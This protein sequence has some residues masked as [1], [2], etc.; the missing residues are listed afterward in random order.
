MSAIYQRARPVRWEDIVGQEHI[1]DV[2]RTALEQGK[3]GHAYLF[4]GPRGVGK[5][6]TARLIAMTANC[7]T[8]TIKPCGECENCLTVRA[9][10]HPDVTEID[11]ASNNSVNDIRDLREKVTLAAM[12]GGKKIYI[13]DEAHMMSKSAFNAFLKTLEEPPEHV[14]FI[15]AT[16]E[17][18]KIIPTIL[19]RCQHYRFRR[20]TAEEI[21]SKLTLLVDAEGLEADADALKL[22]GRLADGAM[23]DGE[24]LLE[25]MLTTGEHITRLAVERALGLPP[26]ERVSHIAQALVSD[27]PAQTFETARQLYQ[28]G[29]AA[30]TIVSGLVN[31]LSAALHTEL[32]I[33]GEEQLKLQ[34]AKIPRLLRL[35]AALDQQ[36]ERFVRSADGQSLELAL[37]H[38]L[39]AA[40]TTDATGTQIQTAPT[41]TVQAQTNQPRRDVG[42][43]KELLQRL[44][45]LE[46]AFAQLAQSTQSTRPQSAPKTPH[47]TPPHS[48]QVHPSQEL[49]TAK[50]T[51]TSH[52]SHNTSQSGQT[53]PP[54]TQIHSAQA[55]QVTTNNN[56]WAELLERAD[57]ELRAFLRPVKVDHQG[58]HLYL[59]Y[60]DKAKFHAEH[61]VQSKLEQLLTLVL[62]TFGPVTLEVTGP[63]SYKRV[64]GRPQPPVQSAKSTPS[65]TQTHP[66]A[67][68]THPQ[69]I[70]EKINEKAAS[71][72]LPAQ[73]RAAP[74]ASNISS[75]RNASFFESVEPSGTSVQNTAQNKPK[76]ASQHEPPQGEPISELTNEYTIITE[77]PDWDML[78]SPYDDVQQ[79][80]PTTP[81]APPAS[82]NNQT[83]EP[84][85]T[86]K[87]SQAKR[88]TNTQGEQQNEQ[89]K[90]PKQTQ[91]KQAKQKPQNDKSTT[92]V[93]DA[94]NIRTHPMYLVITK[95]FQGRVCQMGEKRRMTSTTDAEMPDLDTTDTDAETDAD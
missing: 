21:A 87:P 93:Q 30:R 71:D 7:T 77:E 6:T 39:L 47:S 46:N 27:D 41:Q 70:N 69:A 86:P 67:I 92:D 35:Q 82:A 9:G 54:Q 73:H 8:S 95:N 43:P 12:R 60:T 78:G 26:Y 11:A 88:K 55:T 79:V 4:S 85:P 81:P 31:A 89:Q 48:S 13:L 19:S 44:S 74:R 5:T 1:K 14:I 38:A 33:A 76:Q 45:K 3:V 50:E 64:L 24:S 15:L 29:F 23:R 20:L 51:P 65:T 37:T 16:T 22:I 32:N 75:S 90:Q 57:I 10:S 34:G 62:E 17:P 84:S 59:R 94:S 66:Q 91:K 56:P 2:L 42:V 83:P 61:L 36:D 25:R 68:Q 18:E 80:S 28:D 53:P 63:V 72:K 58:Q 49:K 52:I 40:N